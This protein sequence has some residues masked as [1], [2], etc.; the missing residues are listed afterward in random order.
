MSSASRQISPQP[1]FCSTL[2]VISRSRAKE[3]MRLLS[4][5]PYALETQA[6]AFYYHNFAIKEGPQTRLAGSR[7][8]ASAPSHNALYQSMLALGYA[9]LSQC[10]SMGESRLQAPGF[11][12]KAYIEAVR[13]VTFAVTR[14]EET[15][16]DGTLLAVH[17]MAMYET[18]AQRRKDVELSTMLSAWSNHVHGAAA[19]LEARGTAQFTNPES[20]RLFDQTVILLCMD[21]IKHGLPLPEN[22][23]KM[24]LQARQRMP[25]RRTPR[26]R[27]LDL[28]VQF[29]NF[30]GQV[31]SHRISD[32]Q[33]ILAQAQELDA[34][35]QA[36]FE[37]ADHTMLYGTV[38]NKPKDLSEER[39]G[40]QFPVY[41]H[42]YPSFH[43]AELWNGN[44]VIRILLNQMT[45]SFLLRGMA[46]RPPLFSDSAH[47]RLLQR[48]M[49][50]LR[51]LQ[52]EVICSLPQYLGLRHWEGHGDNNGSDN[53]S[54]TPLNGEAAADATS[55]PSFL[56]NSWPN[57]REAYQ[58]MSPGSPNTTT[59]SS[60]EHDK[61]A[62]TTTTQMMAS[63]TPPLI[64]IGRLLGTCSLLELDSHQ[65]GSCQ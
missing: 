1:T 35:A 39:S 61:S 29:C 8:L 27:S 47:T 3:D 63:M 7:G 32:Y 9:G 31:R 62:T 43:A 57:T 53:G 30:Y 60:S 6:L 16:I 65:A 54:A 28:L 34:Q 48:S 12:E 17:L 33:V 25:E 46:M 21:C 56:W 15:A 51:I 37:H 40:I 22:I 36:V 49:D 45:R 58:V 41:H 44:R 19:L 5:P 64:K 23:C 18:T 59:G 52:D 55:G 4:E 26:L 11:A 50:T 13:A 24:Y 14:P 38:P 42:K 20:M 10:A 2:P